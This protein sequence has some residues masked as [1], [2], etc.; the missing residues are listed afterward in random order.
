MQALQRAQ[1]GANAKLGV[2][3]ASVPG[4][5]FGQGRFQ[6]TSQCHVFHS[7]SRAFI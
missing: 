4:L 3:G 7:D 2:S 6:S 1:L 5:T